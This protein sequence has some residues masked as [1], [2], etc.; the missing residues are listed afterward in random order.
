MS[1]GFK[2]KK[3]SLLGGVGDTPLHH[4]GEEGHFHSDI[5]PGSATGYGDFY[6]VRDSL[7]DVKA[8]KDLDAINFILEEKYQPKLDSAYN[9]KEE[10][11]N[12]VIDQYYKDAEEG[13][14]KSQ[15]EA[16]EAGKEIQKFVDEVDD[17]Y[18]DYVRKTNKEASLESLTAPWT[19]DIRRQ[20]QKE[21]D[22][23]YME[24][25]AK[26]IEAHKQGKISKEELMRRHAINE[27]EYEKTIR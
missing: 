12:K 22:V 25:R 26:D 13:K 24:M 27:E 23:I 4:P 7:S 3:P 2:M 20:N 8:K 21:V 17:E 11:L 5:Q 15:E 18:Q 1:T 14:Y 9:A 16:D 10:R 6:S 19:Y